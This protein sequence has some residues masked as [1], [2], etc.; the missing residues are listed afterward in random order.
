MKNHLIFIVV[1]IFGLTSFAQAQPKGEY[2]GEIKIMGQTVPFQ[3]QFK[4]SA[5]GELSG[6]LDVPAQGAYGLKLSA[7]EQNESLLN[8]EVDTVQTHMI[9]EGKYMAKKDSIYGKYMQSGYSGTFYLAAAK[10]ELNS[11]VDKEVTF[12]NDKIKLAGLLSLPDTVKKHPAVIFISGSGQQDRDENILGFKI[13]KKLSEPFIKNGYAVLRY[14]DRATGKSDKTDI[15]KLTTEDNAQD[16]LAA[17]NFMK[18]HP[19]IDSEKIGMLGHSEGAVI[20]NM[21]A[22]ESDLAFV[23]MMGGP[24]VEGKELLI[25][26]GVSVSKA[27]GRDSAYL[28]SIRKY[29]NKIF[30]EALSQN[31]DTTEIYKLLDESFELNDLGMDAAQ[32]ELYKKQQ[33]QSL[34]LPWIQF[35]LRYNPGDD[36]KTV[37]CPV[38][39]VYGGK[40]TQ[41]PAEMNMKRIEEI[42]RQY[43]K[44]NIQTLLLPEANHLFQDAETGSPSEYKDLP[45]EFTNGFTEAVIKWLKSQNIR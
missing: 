32:L 23:I 21:L 7:L 22:L 36:L 16:A 6:L 10:K 41:V 43:D 3:V 12:R 18:Q 28:A 24:A 45:P 20:A 26:Q 29:N 37:K 17:Y 5:S 31:P 42:I 35:F 9:F 8:F 39:A 25:E 38:L 40:D 27:E 13:F 2:F 15:T 34:M 4:K 30:D 19:N 1:L 44:D 14:D 11:W 33:V